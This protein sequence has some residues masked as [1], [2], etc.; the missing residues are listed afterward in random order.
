MNLSFV[1]IDRMIE[2]ESKKHP[3]GKLGQGTRPTRSK[4]RALS[5]EQLLEKLKDWGISFNRETFIQAASEFISA[6]DWA[7]SLWEQYSIESEAREVD[8]VWIALTILWERWL[9]EQPSFESIDDHMQQGYELLEQNDSVRAC[10]AWLKTWNQVLK[11]ARGKMISTVSQ[12]DDLFCGTQSLFNWSQDFELEL[13]NAA[14]D[15][16]RFFEERIHFTENFLKQFNDP[17]FSERFTAAMAESYFKLGK[18]EKADEL[19]ERVVSTHPKWGWGWIH[20]SDCYQEGGR[21]I[22]PQLDRSESILRRAL[23]IPEVEDRDSLLERLIE[24]LTESGRG[25]EA[26][27]LQGELKKVRSAVKSGRGE[28]L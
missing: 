18:K 17:Y 21:S 26:E 22:T 2:E 7:E 1:A 16:P 10:E 24:V 14:I 5:D 19:F 13:L 9:P 15:D 28:G 4:G 3:K 12:W 6:Q 8:W 20:W 11:I 23:L 25:S 27:L